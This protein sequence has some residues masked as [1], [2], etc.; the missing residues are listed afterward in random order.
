MVADDS[1]GGSPKYGQF[2]PVYVFASYTLFQTESHFPT[3]STF[4]GRGKW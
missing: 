3:L 4:I 2:Q 1:H